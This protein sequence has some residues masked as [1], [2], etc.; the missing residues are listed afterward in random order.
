MSSKEF[1]RKNKKIIILTLAFILFNAIVFVAWKMTLSQGDKTNE[2][3]NQKEINTEPN[4]A[5]NQKIIQQEQ[6]DGT[7]FIYDKETERI[8]EKKFTDGSF[9][10][11]NE[12]GDLIRVRFATDKGTT[13]EYDAKTKNIQKRIDYHQNSDKI[14]S[15]IDYDSSIPNKMLKVTKFKSDGKEKLIV[16]EY[17]PSTGNKKTQIQYKDNQDKVENIIEYDSQ[18]HENRKTKEIAFKDDETTPLLVSYYDK[19]TGNIFKDEKY[20]DEENKISIIIDYNPEVQERKIKETILKPDGKKPSIVIEFDLQN[21]NITKE[22][23]YRENEDSIKSVAN[24]DPNDRDKK[25]N[26]IVLKPDGEKPLKITDYDPNTG[27]KKRTTNFKEKENIIKNFIDYDLHTNE[28]K[29]KSTI[30]KPDG[31]KPS[32]ITDFDTRTRNKIKQTKYQ[33]NKDE[34]ETIIE[35]DPNIANKKINE[36]TFKEDGKTPSLF[37]KYDEGTGNVLECIEYQQDK[38]IIDTI[39]LYDPQEDEKIKMMKKYKPDGIKPSIILYFHEHTGKK[40]KQEE[41]KDDEDKIET[42]IEYNPDTEKIIRKTT[43][44]DDGV[45]IK[46]I[47]TP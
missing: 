44:E 14:D 19:N 23:E 40:T 47:T 42:M 43:Y 18:T 35:F 38:N 8:I 16:L 28:R 2:N 31:E 37:F 22:T 5:S 10:N 27:K 39:T 25:I 4:D 29:S 17:E 7:I 6:P 13:E 46:E 45:T 9:Q 36:T 15:I 33:D 12:K 34:I 41:Y 26:E 21:G 11:F 20:S 32:L 24:Y 3:V 1:I 30:L